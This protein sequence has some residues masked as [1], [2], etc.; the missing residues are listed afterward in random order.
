LLVNW[1]N[2]INQV[3]P[4]ESLALLEE[5]VGEYQVSYNAEL[6]V[7][8]GGAIG[9]VTYDYARNIEV[10]PNTAKDDLQVPDIYFYLFDS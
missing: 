10:L 4:G 7:F 3:L 6:P 8:Q 5:L 2:G 9:F 1:R